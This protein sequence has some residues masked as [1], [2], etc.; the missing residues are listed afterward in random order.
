VP[1]HTAP[2]LERLQ[3]TG[4]QR[5]SSQS[6]VKRYNERLILS[7]LRMHG[8]LPRAEIARR[9]G[10]SAQASSQI[11]GALEDQGLVIAGERQKRGVGQP[12]IPMRLNPDGA[13]SIGLK[14]GRRNAELMLMDL[15]GAARHS[16]R[17]TYRYPEPDAITTFLREGL[18]EILGVLP[19]TLSP[20]L[21]GIGLASPSE[22][23]SWQREVGLPESVAAAWR[24]CGLVE[25]TEQVLRDFGTSLPLLTSNDAT[26]ACAAE[27]AFGNE[28]NFDDFLYVFV[29]TLVGGGVVLNA[30]LCV[31][32]SGYAG[33]I[34]S[35]PV[36]TDID[37]RPRYL[38]HKS[39]IYVLE[40]ALAQSG[41]DPALLQALQDW[42]SIA[43]WVAPWVAEAASGIAH[44]IASS[45][46]VLDFQGVIVDGAFPAT[47]RA[48]LVTAIRTDLKVL[49]PEGVVAC[50][51]VEGK[52]G[53]GARVM[54]AASLPLLERF[55]QDRDVLFGGVRPETDMQRKRG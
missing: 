23:G 1:E 25:R 11:V 55:H 22:L 24:A 50:D 4:T 43:A 30:S 6:G 28:R 33:S 14:V 46:C 49:Q 12:S 45:L 2:D 21:C 3:S 39:S 34:G 13:F 51:V 52:I 27:L 9:S 10:L 16:V 8:P 48:A 42:D 20:R 32:R 19:P 17:L 37:G 54:G 41:R 7:M 29:S 38:V 36:G 40:H 35:M 53:T 44:A 15:V 47:V 26:A 18:Q 5:R 31:G